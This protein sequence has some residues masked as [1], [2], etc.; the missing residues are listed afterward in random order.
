MVHQFPTEP[1]HAMGATERNFLS[2]PNMR[3]SISDPEKM[4]Q[5][6]I[7]SRNAT[8]CPFPCPKTNRARELA[9]QTVSSSLEELNRQG[10]PF[11][12]LKRAASTLPWNSSTILGIVVVSFGHQ[13]YHH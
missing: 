13:L 1:F 7:R 4:L 5:R 11:F 8:T 10:I 12:G 3:S 6:G 2:S 9:R